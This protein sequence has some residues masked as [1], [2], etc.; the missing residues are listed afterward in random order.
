MPTDPVAANMLEG[1]E[2]TAKCRQSL[3]E[4]ALMSRLTAGPDHLVKN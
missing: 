3:Y 4:R 1:V 2:K